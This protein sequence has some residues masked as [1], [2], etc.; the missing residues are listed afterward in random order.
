M[1]RSVGAIV[2][3][4]VRD[5]PW[6]IVL[7]LGVIGLA[8]L[9]GLY[10]SPRVLVLVGMGI[11]VFV[12]V[13][14]LELGLLGLV[15]V[16]LVVPFTIGTGTE[17]SLNLAVLF[18]PV[19]LGVWVLDMVRQR[20]VRL[21]QSSVNRPL[22]WFL[23]AGLLSLAVGNVMWNPVVPRPGNLLLVQL[24]QWAIFALSAGAFWLSG[25]LIREERWLRWVT[26]CFLVLSG[27]LTVARLVWGDW[28][29]IG[30][31]ATV[32]IIRAP[33]WISLISI[34]GGQLLF[35]RGMHVRW[36]WCLLALLFAALYYAFV[37]ER[38]SISTWAPLLVVFGV[39]LW[40]RYPR[41]RWPLVL[42][43]LVGP[44]LLFQP[45][46]EFAG[47]DQE[48]T[49]SGGARLALI[50]RTIALTRENPLLGL[51]PA[52]YRHYGFLEPLRYEKALW[53]RASVSA[54]NNYV[55]LYAQVGLVGLGLFLWFLFELARLGWRLREIYVEGFA[56][57]YVNGMLAALAGICAAMLLLD[58]F[59]PFVYNVGFP[60]FQA[61][62]LLWMFFGGLVSL[63]AMART[64]EGAVDG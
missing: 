46:Y 33:Y 11:G 45:L 54:H 56:A 58:W 34:L 62:V 29:L 55:D 49:V 4:L 37:S 42:C 44:V 36:R 35:N 60:G 2:D 16:A 52:S 51:G 48:W 21:V 5:R 22:L 32:A 23:G 47:G 59:L 61:S 14:Y 12:L 25:N 64:R 9:A 7:I 18:V 39:L 63:E 26:V 53:M 27:A 40:L 30:R 17:V 1:A 57:G 20:D 50:R 6:R 13:R 10:T 19:L 43:A 41:L 15:V 8:F 24:G 38:E 28:Q 3:Q 31:T